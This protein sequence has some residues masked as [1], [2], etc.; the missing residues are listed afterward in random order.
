MDFPCQVAVTYKY[1]KERE[2]KMNTTLDPRVK[3]QINI[4]IQ[5]ALE[6][7][8]KFETHNYDSPN[9]NGYAG[10]CREILLKYWDGKMGEYRNAM[11]VSVYVASDTNRLKVE[12]S[13]YG[14]EAGKI[15]KRDIVEHIGYVR[16]LQERRAA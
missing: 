11:W 4:Y 13:W 7:G 6:Q 2:N 8:V 9:R 10:W 1:L 16:E 15:A 14:Y 3:D 5:E 12:A